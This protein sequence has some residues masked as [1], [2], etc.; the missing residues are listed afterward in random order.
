MLFV[1]LKDSVVSDGASV[2]GEDGGGLRTPSA[3]AA[4]LHRQ[5]LEVGSAH[6]FMTIVSKKLFLNP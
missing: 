6:L 1:M 4:V 2:H 3:G 5:R